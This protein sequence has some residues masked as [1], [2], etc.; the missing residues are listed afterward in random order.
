METFLYRR[1]EC[2]NRWFI[3]TESGSTTVLINIHDTHKDSYQI[4]NKYNIMIRN[5]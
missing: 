5:L 3:Y 4:Q 1:P 2:R